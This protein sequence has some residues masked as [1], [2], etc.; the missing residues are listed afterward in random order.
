[1]VVLTVTGGGGGRGKGGIVG[2][3]WEKSDVAG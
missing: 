1:M 2:D 3:D